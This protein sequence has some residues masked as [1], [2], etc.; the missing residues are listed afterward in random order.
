MVPF[1]SFVADWHNLSFCKSDSFQT[2]PFGDA[3]GLGLAIIVSAQNYSYDQRQ[4]GIAYRADKR[5]L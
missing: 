2:T 4:S 1:V 3:I 5:V